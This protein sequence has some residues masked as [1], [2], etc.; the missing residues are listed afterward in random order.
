LARGNSSFTEPLLQHGVSVKC[1]QLLA[2]G[3]PE[4]PREIMAR[5][6]TRLSSSGRDARDTVLAQSAMGLLAQVI[7]TS[8]NNSLPTLLNLAKAV[9]ALLRDEPSP[10]FETIAAAL[11]VC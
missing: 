7:L 4:W 1:L 10:P 2:P 11:P 3:Q 9:A 8:Q 6:V 5:V